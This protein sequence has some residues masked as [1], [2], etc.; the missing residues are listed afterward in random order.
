MKYFKLKLEKELLKNGFYKLNWDGRIKI[1]AK[2]LKYP[3][4]IRPWKIMIIPEWH[5]WIKENNE[6]SMY[7]V[8]VYPEDFPNSGGNRIFSV[9]PHLLFEACSLLEKINEGFT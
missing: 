6:L 3:Y 7:R 9:K 1:F 5:R 2:D 4:K 8:E